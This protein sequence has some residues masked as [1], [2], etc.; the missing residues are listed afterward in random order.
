MKPIEEFITGLGNKKDKQ[1][2][3]YTPWSNLR[4]DGSMAVGQVSFKDAK[5]VKKILVSARDNAIVNR[6]NKTRDERFPDLRQEK[7]TRLKELRRRDHASQLERVSGKHVSLAW[8][9]RKLMVMRCLAKGGGQGGSRAK[10][11][12]LAEGPRLRRALHRG[13]PGPV[14]QPGSRGGL[15]RRFHVDMI[16]SSSVAK[17]PRTTRTYAM[18]LDHVSQP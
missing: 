11:E 8:S 17:H 7:E 2:I 14:Q 15:P 10:G 4:K 6:L 9:R 12:S 5:Q 18:S 1:T 13:E 16:Q 3:I